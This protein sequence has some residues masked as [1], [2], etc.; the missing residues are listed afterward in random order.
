MF[1]AIIHIQVVT[2][3]LPRTATALKELARGDELGALFG[4]QVA[5]ASELVKADAQSR[6]LR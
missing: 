4:K 5:D 6:Q 3:L 1:V 2:T